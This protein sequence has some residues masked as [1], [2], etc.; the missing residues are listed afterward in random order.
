MSEAKD[1]KRVERDAMRRVIVRRMEDRPVDLD[2]RPMPV[3]AE[4]WRE[5]FSQLGIECKKGT[6]R[7]WRMALY[8]LRFKYGRLSLT[9]VADGEGGRIGQYSLLR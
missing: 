3:L 1:R 4:G 5:F 9:L 7:Q 8:S 6:R 2:G